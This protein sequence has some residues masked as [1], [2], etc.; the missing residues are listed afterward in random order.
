[1]PGESE[2]FLRVVRVPKADAAVAVGGG[3]HLA[4]GAK[5]DRCDP[6]GVFLDFVLQLAGFGG[7]DFDQPSGAAEGNLGLIRTDV[8]SEDGVIFI[9]DGHEPFARDDVP[10]QHTARFAA[11]SAAS[12]VRDEAA[13]KAL[14]ETI[15]G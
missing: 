5:G 15:D 13:K 11:M 4:I 9:A 1:M 8:G 3:Q 7:I 10:H 14:I 12:T 2:E 6:I